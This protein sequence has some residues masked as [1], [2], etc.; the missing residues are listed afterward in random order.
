M[1]AALDVVAVVLLLAG[2]LLML[3]GSVGL[4]RLPDFFARS[5][6]AGNTD[7]L[8]VVVILAG[9]MVLEGWTLQSAKLGLVAIFAGLANPVAIHAL[10]RAAFR[11]GV[12]PRLEEEAPQQERE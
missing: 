8:G 10:A 9:L 1:N 3:A 2:G 6:S 4:L 11:F 12:R 5:H 7:T